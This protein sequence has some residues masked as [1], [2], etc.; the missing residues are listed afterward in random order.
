MSEKCSQCNG[1]GIVQTSFGPKP[2]PSFHGSGYTDSEEATVSRHNNSM[3]AISILLYS[4]I[5]GFM[6]LFYID[7]KC[8][9]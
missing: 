1:T 8:G 2:C 9:R 5:A 3:S 6:G 7:I 4:A